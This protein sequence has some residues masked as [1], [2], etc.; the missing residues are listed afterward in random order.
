[1]TEPGNSGEAYAAGIA[2]AASRGITYL[3]VQE[4]AQGP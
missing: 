4:L 3:P 2:L 1:M